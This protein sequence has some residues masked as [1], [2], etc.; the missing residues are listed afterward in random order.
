MHKNSLR[1]LQNDFNRY[2]RITNMQQILLEQ[3]LLTDVICI[4]GKTSYDKNS[5]TLTT[6]LSISLD[7]IGGLPYY[8]FT[9]VLGDTIHS[10]E[11]W[12]I[13]EYNKS[14]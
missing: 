5:L 6:T 14:I 7:R 11:L 4:P 13:P 3:Y 1:V 9:K 2:N 8:Y 10:Q 12:V